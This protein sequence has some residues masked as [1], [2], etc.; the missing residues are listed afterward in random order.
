[1]IRSVAPEASEKI[2]YQMPTFVLHGNLVHF[3][4]FR[5]HI[6]FYPTPS[7]TEKFKQE[8]AAY[9]NAKGS[10]R[11]PL[12]KP[13]PLDLIHRITLFRV[14]ENLQKAQAQKKT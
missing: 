3:A 1:M 10:I 7:G 8:I 14:Q 9:Q 11:F 2:N 13:M 5:H 12:D 6:G 4:A